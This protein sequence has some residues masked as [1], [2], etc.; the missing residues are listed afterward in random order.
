M[1]LR[2]LVRGLDIHCGIRISVFADGSFVEHLVRTTL[3]NVLLGAVE[4][5]T[6]DTHLQ[7]LCHTV[8]P[9]GARVW[10][11]EVHKRIVLAAC[12]TGLCG[13]SIS[14]STLC[15]RRFIAAE[16]PGAQDACCGPSTTRSI[17][18]VKYSSG[19]DSIARPHFLMSVAGDAVIEKTKLPA[20]GVIANRMRWPSAV[21]VS[22][23]HCRFETVVTP[24]VSSDGSCVRPLAVSK[25]R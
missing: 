13:Q 7:Q 21:R 12:R 9:E 14:M 1:F 6:R 15:P 24:R 10:I 19:L 8:L 20:R 23:L 18:P 11:G 17:S 25:K 3:R 5:E 4:L 16:I 2:D 22:P